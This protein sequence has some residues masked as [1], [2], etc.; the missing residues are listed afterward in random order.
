MNT[1]S[2]ASLAAPVGFTPAALLLKRLGAIRMAAPVRFVPRWRADTA[3]ALAVLGLI[4]LAAAIPGVL[5]PYAPTDLDHGAVL[6]APSAR[7]WAGTDHLGRDIFSLIVFGA[8][9]TLLVALSSVAIG[10][11]GGTALGLACGYGGRWFDG[12]VTR[13]IEI[14]LAIPD[15]LLVIVLATALTPSMGNVVLTIGVVMIPRGSRIVRA[16]GVALRHR[17]F[18]T[19]ARALGVSERSILFDHVLPHTLSPLLVMATLGVAMAAL[20]GSMISFLGLGAVDDLPDWGYLISQARSYLTV[21][22]W[23]GAFPGVAITLFV[24]AVNMLGD[25]LRISFN[26]RAR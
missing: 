13:L 24:I 2:L 4:V 23:M 26:P 15:V 5:A 9:Q 7:H 17:P 14:W 18:I 22:W 16:Q 1:R 3:L 25:R 20:M 19:A 12:A 6:S 8:R 21:A 10:T 11:L